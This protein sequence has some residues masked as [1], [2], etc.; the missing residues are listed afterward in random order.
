VIG[1]L[2]HTADAG[3]YAAAM[4]C[5]APFALLVAAG[6]LPLGSVV[7]RLGAAGE[8][9]RLQRGLR[10]ATR[11]VAAASA[12]VAAALLVAPGWVLGLFGAGFP[13]GADALR[14][15]AVAYLINAICAFNGLV[16]IMGGEERAAMHAAFAALVLDA[17]LCL[18]LVPPMGARG[19]A[20]ALLVSV[21]A[22]NAINSAVARRRLGIDTTVVGRPKLP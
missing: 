12:L 22:R 20:L 10:T 14:I 9:A 11:G 8:R 17:G 7:A 6:R 4:Q 5:C 3:V 21:T 16:L 15:L 18:A 1:A 2:G 19:A 13:A